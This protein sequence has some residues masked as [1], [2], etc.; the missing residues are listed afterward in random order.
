M[1]LAQTETEVIYNPSSLLSIFTSNLNNE[2]TRKVFKVKGIY[3]QGK[4][5]NYNGI[6]Y[7]NIRDETTDACMTLIVPALIR[8]QLDQNQTIECHAYLTKKMQ[9]NAGRIDLQ[10]NLVQLLSNNSTT[11]SETQLK[12]FEILEK[13]ATL[14]R[15]DVDTF[16]KS[17]II[18]DEPISV[19]IIIGKSAI[20]HEDIK[21]QLQDA[22][23][24]YKIHFRQITLTSVKEI[25]E[26]LNFYNGKTD[27]IAIARGGGENLEIFDNPEI[28]EVALSLS[29]HFITA[30]GHAENVPLLQK[31]AD[32]SFITPTALGQ[33]LNDIYNNTKAELQNSKA[34]LIDDVT[35][36]LEAGYGKQIENLKNEITSVE[37]S[38][39]SEVN[40]L[41]GQLQ[42]AKEEKEA[43]TNQVQEL[44]KEIAKTKGL[45]ISTILLIIAALIIG[46]LIGRI[47]M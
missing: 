14:G 1:T 12:A 38:K 8:S 41:T 42:T 15:K 25:I 11:F 13:K 4:G 23:A 27:I 18:N 28:S 5:N 2:A 30:L 22:I 31:I 7:D 43:Y 19:N 37:K 35:K 26:N 21:H 20:I 40:I 36:H 29:T 33:Y 34:K 46:L 24:H 3:S 47:F 10:L 6:Y 16:I 17:K 45:S 32:K 9:Q 39:Q 44:Q